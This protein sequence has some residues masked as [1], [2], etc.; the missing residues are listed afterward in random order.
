M[1]SEM[2]PERTVLGCT[3]SPV[4]DGNADVH[5]LGQTSVSFQVIGGQGS[6]E[7]I[8]V[9]RSNGFAGGNGLADIV[10]GILHINHQVP[11]FTDSLAYQADEPSVVLGIEM[12]KTSRQLLELHGPE[13]AL[14]AQGEALANFFPYCPEDKPSHR[15]PHSS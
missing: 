7:K 8:D 13:A 14:K 4:P 15:E 5:G 11:I 1:I 10:P 6:L 3:T 9:I 12:A 2:P